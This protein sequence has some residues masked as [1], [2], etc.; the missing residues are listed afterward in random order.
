MTELALLQ[1]LQHEL[2]R[3]GIRARSGVL[4]RD[5]STMCVGGPL[6]LLV[7]PQSEAE[8]CSLMQLLNAKR[9]VPRILGA[10]SNILI[11]D[12]G[13][14]D[15]VIRLGR[16]FRQVQV[17]AR[18]V[19]VGGAMSLMSLSRDLSQAGLS[20]LEFAGGIPASLGGAVRMNAGAHGG[21]M[22]QVLQRVRLCSAEGNI[23]ELSASELGL[24]YRRCL[25][26]KGA[27]VVDALLE[28]V[29]G[30]RDEIAARRQHFLTERKLRQPLHLP[31][32]GSVFKNPSAERSAGA[33]LEAAGM[34]GRALGGAS[35]SSQHANWIVN[36]ERK[37][38]A[39]DVK[40]LIQLC[41]TA[42]LTQAGVELEPEI[43]VW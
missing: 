24:S 41:R 13:V 11:P 33:I 35:V 12:Q 18:Q 42:A 5:C 28:L 17:N 9:A 4:G 3:A 34:K 25:L 7:E 23:I 39:E 27:I 2:N 14:A 8:L 38:S 15:V 6:A 21:E 30:N 37:A 36:Q 29:E 32:S 40:Q 1:S 20:G 31:S 16:A 19:L 43:V 26:P 22:A 10:G